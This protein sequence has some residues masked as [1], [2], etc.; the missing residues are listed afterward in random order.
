MLRPGDTEWLALY[1]NS[2][3]RHYPL[4]DRR[5]GKIALTE[6]NSA[7]GVWGFVSNQVVVLRAGYASDRNETVMREFKYVYEAKGLYHKVG[8][9]VEDAEAYEGWAWM[10]RH[11]D[12]KGCVLY[13]P[14]VQLAP[15]RYKVNFRIKKN[16]SYDRCW[17]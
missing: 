5:N 16:G 4:K 15:G 7:Y 12:P 13:G 2:P 8:R 10:V 1:L 9:A 17:K 14:Y 11:D 6:S 3:Y